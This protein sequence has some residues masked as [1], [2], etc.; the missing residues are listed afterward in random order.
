MFGTWLLF[1]YSCYYSVQN[2][3]IWGKLYIT[4]CSFHIMLTPFLY[5]SIYFKRHLLM[6]R[7]L[8][9]EGSHSESCPQSVQFTPS[10]KE[11]ISFVNYLC[12]FQ[13]F[14]DNI[15]M[16]LH[17]LFFNTEVACYTTF[18]TL[19]SHF[20]I[21]LGDLTKSTQRPPALWLAFHCI[22]FHCSCVCEC[23]VSLKLIGARIF[24][25]FC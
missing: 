4:Q 17:S 12:I 6:Q 22:I 25:I 21:Y 13:F 24:P 5:L 1:W 11:V 8:N 16:T 3:N 19:F 10:P 18:F 2:I 7:R 9:S 23:L 15:I 14:H 20:T